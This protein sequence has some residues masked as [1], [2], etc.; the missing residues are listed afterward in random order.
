[1]LLTFV[2]L[3]SAACHFRDRTQPFSHGRADDCIPRNYR[4]LPTHRPAAAPG[5]PAPG[6]AAPG[7]A[8]PGPAAPGGSQS[9]SHKAAA[10]TEKKANI[11]IGE[12]V[13]VLINE[14]L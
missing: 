14:L 10:A 13:S 5:T 3:Y 4:R 9:Q 12:D 7:P 6:S 1:M 8:A 11:V 2:C